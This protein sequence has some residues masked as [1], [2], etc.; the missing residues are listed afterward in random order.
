MMWGDLYRANKVVSIGNRRRRKKK[1]ARYLYRKSIINFS[2]PQ[3]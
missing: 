1:K 2:R 3:M